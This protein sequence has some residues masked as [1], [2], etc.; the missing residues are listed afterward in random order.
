LARSH[1]G[2]ITLN[3]G[4]LNGGLLHFYAIL[5]MPKRYFLVA[6]SERLPVG[7][8]KNLLPRLALFS[9]ILSEK[10]YTPSNQ[11]AI[12]QFKCGQSGR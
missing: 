10:H 8:S 11:K 9:V 12:A 4:T 7:P 1:V 5:M 6:L 2:V 3:G